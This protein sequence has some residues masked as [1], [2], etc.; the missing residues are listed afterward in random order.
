MYIYGVFGPE[1][2][3][4][5]IISRAH[6]YGANDKKVATIWLHSVDTIIH[7]C[8]RLHTYSVRMCA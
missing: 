4:Q 6:K 5:Y 3:L 2:E 7:M 8:L 1:M